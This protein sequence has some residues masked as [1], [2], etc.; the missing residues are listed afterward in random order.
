[1]AAT[2]AP[3]EHLKFESDSTLRWYEASDGVF[4]GFCET[5]GSSLFWKAGDEPDGVSIC[6]GPLDLPTGLETTKVVWMAEVSDYH[7]PQP[8]LNEFE[9]DS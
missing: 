6:A 8:N 9:H 3:T 2:W 4:Y 5:C 7:I 1:M